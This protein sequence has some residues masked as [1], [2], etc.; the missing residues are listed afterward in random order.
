MTSEQPDTASPTTPEYEQSLIDE[1]GAAG[2]AA[3]R[4]D[5]LPLLRYGDP[6]TALNVGAAAPPF[7]LTDAVGT[8]YSLTS[9]LS[10][11]PV[12]LIFYRGGWCPFCNVQLRAFQLA[13][14]RLRALKANV[15]LISPERF[16]ESLSLIERQSLQFPVLSD[17]GNLVARQYGVAVRLDQEQRKRHLEQEID[18]V[19]SNGDEAWELPMPATFVIDSNRRIRYAFVSADYTQRAEPAEVLAVLQRMAA[20]R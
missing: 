16:Q 7:T 2:V 12:V 14:M 1:H 6:A 10:E 15:L 18:L 13:R 4:A 11:G 20:G 5:V 17:V 9:L 3:Y 19:E 8:P